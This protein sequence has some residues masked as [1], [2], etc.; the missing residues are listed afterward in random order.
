[1]NWIQI[2]LSTGLPVLVPHIFQQKPRNHQAK[3][4]KELS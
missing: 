1:M 3:R 2:Y 4:R